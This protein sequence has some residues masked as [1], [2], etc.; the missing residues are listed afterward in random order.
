MDVSMPIMDG[1]EATKA[2]RKLE[3]E[4]LV[5]G[6]KKCKIVGLTAHSND[7]YK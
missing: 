7:T 3:E 1:F 6:E 5:P 2:I 4:E